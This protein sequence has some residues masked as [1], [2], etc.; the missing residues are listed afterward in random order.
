MRNG[1]RKTMETILIIIGTV[2]PI[3]I[4]IGVTSTKIEH[5]LTKVET[6]MKWLKR[7][8]IENKCCGDKEGES[9]D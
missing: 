7:S 8:A 4:A 2:T 9:G 6:D 5:R 1:R 3:I